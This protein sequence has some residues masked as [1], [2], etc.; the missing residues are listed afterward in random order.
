MSHLGIDSQKFFLIL[1]FLFSPFLNFLYTNQV[2][3]AS[4]TWDAN[5]GMEHQIVRGLLGVMLFLEMVVQEVV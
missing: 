1:L 3:A 5:G 4:F 2:M